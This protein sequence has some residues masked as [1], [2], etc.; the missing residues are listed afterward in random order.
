MWLGYKDRAF[1]W[2]EQ[3][4]QYRGQ[5]FGIPMLLL[6]RVPELEPLRSDPRYKDLLILMLVSAAVAAVRPDYC[7][8]ALGARWQIEI[9]LRL[10]CL[11]PLDSPTPTISASAVDAGV[12]RQH[13]CGT[14][15]PRR[16][17]GR[18]LWRTW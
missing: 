18:L 14:H 16:C 1:Y 3:A 12:L 15:R 17:P 13:D 9:G 2:L 6:N 4:Y 11:V 7:R 8:Y 5:T 10:T